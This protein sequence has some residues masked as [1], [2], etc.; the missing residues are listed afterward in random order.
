MLLLKTNICFICSTFKACVVVLKKQLG[1]LY[2]SDPDYCVIYRHNLSLQ[3]HFYFF[4][5]LDTKIWKLKSA[6]VLL[7][8]MQ[9]RQSFANELYVI[10]W[11]RL[12]AIYLVISLAF[13][14]CFSRD[15]FSSYSAKTENFCGFFCLI[16]GQHFFCANFYNF[17]QA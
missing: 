3:N 13:K 1:K 7:L 10:A 15:N 14:C 5:A 6:S 12:A 11:G 2:F 4:W 8:R 9:K 17:D 16:K